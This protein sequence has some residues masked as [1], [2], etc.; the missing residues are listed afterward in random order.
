[1]F[2]LWSYIEMVNGWADVSCVWMA[3][4]INISYLFGELNLIII[5]LAN[6]GVIVQANECIYE[7]QFT[8]M[9]RICA[10]LQQNRL[11]S[12]GIPDGVDS[13]LDFAHGNLPNNSVTTPL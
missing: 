13:W 12:W 5:P 4:Y 3:Q 11:A 10:N 7:A 8:Q 1:M 2:W 6:F 9:W